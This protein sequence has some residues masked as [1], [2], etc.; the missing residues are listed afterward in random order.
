[1]SA[2]P[3]KYYLKARDPKHAALVSGVVF[4]DLRSPWVWLKKESGRDLRDNF[5]VEVVKEVYYGSN[6]TVD[7]T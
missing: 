3:S 4:L 5:T 7:F 6:L 1:M 2:L